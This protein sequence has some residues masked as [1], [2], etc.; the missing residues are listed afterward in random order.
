[1]MDAM[2]E[3]PGPMAEPG[4]TPVSVTSWVEM[5]EALRKPH[6]DLSQDE[7]TALQACVEVAAS[8]C[9][10]CGAA[11]ASLIETPDRILFLCVDCADRLL[12]RC[13]FVETGGN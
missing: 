11:V 13:G 6:P 9:M 4:L 2:N 1:M 7:R 3:W 10:R 12:R 8:G 5:C